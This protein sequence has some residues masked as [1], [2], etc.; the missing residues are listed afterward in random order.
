MAGEVGNVVLT[1]ARR[2]DAHREYRQAVSQA[3]AKAAVGHRGRQ[4]AV[5]GC[6][7]AHLHVQRALGAAG[8]GLTRRRRNH[9]AL[10]P[11][12]IDTWRG[13]QGQSGFAPPTAR[14]AP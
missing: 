11:R 2:R 9:C 4:A 10:D 8:G 14:F 7:D 1:L 13:A 12:V 3:F 5:R 6:D